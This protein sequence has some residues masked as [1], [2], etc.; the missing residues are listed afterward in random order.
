MTTTTTSPAT[1]S[2]RR[3]SG[4]DRGPLLSTAFVLVA[5]LII[6]GGSADS[7]FGSVVILA[8][9]YAIVTAGMAVQIGFS[10]QVVFSQSV[11][12]GLGAYGVAVLNSNVGWPSLLALVVIT[13]ASAG[14]AWVIGKAVSRASGL[15]LAVATLMFPLIAY[16]YVSN[17]NWLGGA[18]GMPLTGNLWPGGSSAT[19]NGILTVVIVTIVVFATTRLVAS[20]IGLEMYVLGVHEKTAQAMGVRTARRRL[21]LF[22]LGSVL[23]TLGGAVYAGTQLFVPPTLVQATAELSLLIML[24]VGGRRSVLGAVLGAVGIQ[25]FIGASNTISVHILLIEGVLITVVLLI[26]PEGIAGIVSRLWRLAAARTRV[27]ARL[28]GPD[29]SMVPPPI[30]DGDAGVGVSGELAATGEVESTAFRRH[31][32]GRRA[33]EGTRSEALL[34]C[35]SVSKEFGGLTVLRDVDITLPQRGIFGLCGPNGAG[36]TTLL[37]VVGGSLAPTRGT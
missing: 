9:T 29:P 18:I 6:A 24:F 32:A 3:W 37:N 11:F 10:Q 23:A 20:E 34:K 7:Y 21:E 30:L 8:L 36:K 25:Y 14:V 13:I 1:K 35:R 17:A 4:A 27:I 15:A 12:M 28:T 2:G 19:A 33:Y 16:G 22:I 26:E 31:C 5:G